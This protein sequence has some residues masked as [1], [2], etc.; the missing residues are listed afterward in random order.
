VNVTNEGTYKLKIPS[1]AFP[2][3]Q[4]PPTSFGQGLAN[5]IVTLAGS[6]QLRDPIFQ[7]GSRYVRKAASML[8]P[9]A[10]VH[11]NSQP[12]GREDEI[13]APRQILAMQAEA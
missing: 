13:G 12:A 2:N 8:M 5:D 3:G 10:A 11:K 6:G 4:H 1:L 7:P 9:K